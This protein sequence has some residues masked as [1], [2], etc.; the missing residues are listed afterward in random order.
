MLLLLSLR[1][2]HYFSYHLF[3]S[4]IIFSKFHG[5]LWKKPKSR[6]GLICS[7]SFIEGLVCKKWVEDEAGKFLR[8]K[9]QENSFASSL[10]LLCI[11]FWGTSLLYVKRIA[12]T[13]PCSLCRQNNAECTK[14]R[15]F[16]SCFFSLRNA[17]I[18]P[19]IRNRCCGSENFSIAIYVFS[20]PINTNKPTFY[21]LWLYMFNFSS[22]KGFSFCVCFLKQLRFFCDANRA[23]ILF[24]SA[25]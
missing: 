25:V 15:N 6:E 20:D 1:V 8:W 2:P 16:L 10:L 4:S 9:I 13:R 7:I 23:D 24:P 17:R 21:R 19:W 22:T 5:E 3:L 12:N 14:I 11:V 18:F